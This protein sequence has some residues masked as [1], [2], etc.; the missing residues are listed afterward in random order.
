MSKEKIMLWTE[1]EMILRSGS[2]KGTFESCKPSLTFYPSDSSREHGC[3]I[4]CPG[5]GYINKASDYEGEEIARMFN[6]NQISAFVLDYRVSPDRHPAPLNDLLRAI[7]IAKS[8]AN[9]MGYLSDKIAVMGF[10]AGGHL[11]ASASTMWTSKEQR[12]DATILCYPVITMGKAANIDCKTNLF[13]ETFN[14]AIASDMSCENRVDR[15]TPPAFIWHTS[16]DDVV[17]VENSLLYASA[18]STKSVPFELHVFPKGPH[19]LGLAKE[20]KIISSW[21]EMC[22]KWL[23]NLGF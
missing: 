12:P 2:G 4:I 18:L 13:G 15:Q 22:V 11:A 6:L 1:D 9:D 8:S 19:G 10:S 3:V 14:D 21:S 23:L 20:D 7:E 5:G 16:D 17:S